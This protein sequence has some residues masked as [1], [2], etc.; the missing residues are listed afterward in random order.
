MRSAYLA[1][2]VGIGMGMGRG[3]GVSQ[4]NRCLGLLVYAVPVI[5]YLVPVRSI[6]SFAMNLLRVTRRFW[7]SIKT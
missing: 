3:R 2:G 4:C 7:V 1:F 6:L 5:L